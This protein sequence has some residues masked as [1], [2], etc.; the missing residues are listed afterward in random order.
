VTKIYYFS[1][2]GNTL[3]SARKLAALFGPTTELFNIG[4][5]MEQPP[6]M[7]EAERIIIMFPVYAFGV[8]VLV[9]R[10][11]MRHIIHASYI[12][13]LVTCGTV[14]GGA[15]AEVY[16]LLR[17]RHVR[18]S[19]A[20]RIPS[21]ENYIPIFGPPKEK[22]K[23]KRLAAQEESTERAGQ[24]ILAGAVNRPW[25]I[26]PF[27]WIVRTLF[28]LGKRFFVKA[29]TVDGICNGCALCAKICPAAA[30]T[31]ERKYPVF[32][33]HCE[34]CQACLNWCPQRAIGYIRLKQNTP[35]YHHPQ[36]KARDMLRVPSA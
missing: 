29:Y 23:E 19:Y 7:I 30:I 31:I 32:G 21:V 18:L 11:L 35:R 36:V 15:L 20:A 2:T 3:W 16:G 14:S 10:F 4:S 22:T 12:A 8:P 33:S 34:H 24:E 13:A 28:R 1:G 26:R 6:S 27:S 17:R 5:V 9:R 25:L